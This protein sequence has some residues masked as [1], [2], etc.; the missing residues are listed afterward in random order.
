MPAVREGKGELARLLKQLYR[1]RERQR[2]RRRGLAALFRR[3]RKAALVAAFRE[4]WT[5]GYVL[6]DAGELAFV[7]APLDAQGERILFYGFGA[8]SAALAFVPQGGVVID[9]GANL[10]EWSVPLAKAAGAGGKVLCCEPNPAIAA[11]LAATLRINNL[12]QAVVIETAASDTDGEGRLA[13]DPANTGLSRLSDK[14]HGVAVRLCKL[15]TIVA[16]RG[17]GRVDLVK[18]DVE[19]HERLVFDGGLETLRRFGPAVVFES[20]LETAADRGAIA[21]RLEQLGYDIVA[22]LHDHGAL[23]ADLAD[24]RAARAACAGD[25]ARNILA[26]PREAAIPP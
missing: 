4:R 13:I 1:F 5:G 8:P 25:E 11:A 2:E 15:D 18:I 24:Y 10:G 17:L 16:E 7:P 22:V 12:V 9:V 26:L 6:T 20:G 23:P 21:E 19:G 3:R 14:N